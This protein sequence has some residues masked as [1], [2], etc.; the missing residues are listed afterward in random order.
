MCE[1]A[2]ITNVWKT[3]KLKFTAQQYYG[4]IMVTACW[5]VETVNLE[6]QGKGGE[7]LLWLWSMQF[8]D[9]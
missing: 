6:P 5:R 8:G 1:T 4:R 3:N 7:V 2:D 9:S